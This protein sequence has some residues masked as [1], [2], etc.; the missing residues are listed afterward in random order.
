[1]RRVT[2]DLPAERGAPRACPRLLRRA[3]WLLPLLVLV[4]ASGAVPAQPALAATVTPVISGPSSGSPGVPLSFSVTAPGGCTTTPGFTWFTSDSPNAPAGIGP[5]LSHTFTTAGTFTVTVVYADGCGNS[6][7]ASTSV[8]VGQS[9]ASACGTNAPGI[10]VSVYASPSSAAPGV[11]VTFTAIISGGTASSVSWSFG[12]GQTSSTVATG[13]TA[14][15]THTY[16]T[17]GS[18]TATATASTSAGTSC[19]ATVVTIGSGSGNGVTVSAGGPYTGCVNQPVSFNGSAVS[20]SGAAIT[21]YLWSFGDNTTGTGAQT[22][23]TYVAT[24]TYTVTL[25]AIDT[26]NQSNQATTSAV[27][28]TAC[29]CTTSS[30]STVTANGVTV[31]AGGPYTGSAGTPVAFSATASTTNAGA[32][33]VSYVWSFGDGASA[34]GQQTTH[35]YSSNGTY[36]IA[37]VVT[38]SSGHAATATTQATIAGGNRSVALVTGCNNI[39]STFPDNT[40]TGT[41]TNAVQPQSALLSVWK[42]VDPQAVRYHGYFPGASQ[43]TDLPTVNH[44]DAI[45]V[46]VS[47]PAT[48]TEPAE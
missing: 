37:L 19:G 5:T 41:I 48:L 25:T 45:F 40:P 22:S 8:V 44:L 35:S 31:S 18:F 32:T 12:D 6:G 43:A 29:T 10:T 23:H 26:N 20:P 46:C 16:V 21:T 2:A 33:I 38:D 11:P 9:G 30:S 13:N 1:M 36:T 7:Q 15:T 17:A 14:S 34:T 3:T 28:S 27:I 4:S 42:L 24:G 39:A 47:G